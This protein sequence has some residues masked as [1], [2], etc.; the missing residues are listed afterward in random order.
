MLF[1]M[2]EHLLGSDTLEE[3]GAAWA[4]NRGVALPAARRTAMAAGAAMSEMAAAAAAR[5]R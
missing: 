4:H 2:A 5:A 3:M 1:P